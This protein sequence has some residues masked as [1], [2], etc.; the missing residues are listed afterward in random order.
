MNPLDSVPAPIS[1][2][3]GAI[4]IID[5]LPGAGNMVIGTGW[6]GQGWAPAVGH[7]EF[8]TDWVTSGEKPELLKAVRLRGVNLESGPGSFAL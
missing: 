1:V 2:R 8:I 3:S 5:R 4:P 7:A 6:T